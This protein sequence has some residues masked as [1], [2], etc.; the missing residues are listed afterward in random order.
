MCYNIYVVIYMKTY[1]IDQYYPFMRE[2]NEVSVHWVH[3]I[4]VCIREVELEWGVPVLME[5]ITDSQR[6]PKTYH[7]YS[8]YKEA[9]DFIHLLQ[10]LN[11]AKG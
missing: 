10:G 8:T 9:L 6:D 11:G 3:N 5:R 4:R 2:G 1:I 7:V